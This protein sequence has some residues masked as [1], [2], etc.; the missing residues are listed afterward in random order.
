MGER[1]KLWAHYLL[2]CVVPTGCPVAHVQWRWDSM[3]S[4]CWQGRHGG[5]PG[6]HQG[7]PAGQE[8]PFVLPFSLS[9]L[10]PSAVP[11]S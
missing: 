8:E 6:F 10:G 9:W 5:R 11:A 2:S 1:V 7:C 3:A 4:P